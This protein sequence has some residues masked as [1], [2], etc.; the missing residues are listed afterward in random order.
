M[1]W[2]PSK[3]YFGA[4]YNPEQWDPSTWHDDVLAMRDMGVNMVTVGVFSWAV[5]EPKPEKYEFGWLDDVMDLLHNAGV[6]VDLATATASPPPWLPLLDPSVCAVR[7]DGAHYSHGGRQHYSASSRTYREKAAQLV[8]QMAAR[9]SSHPAL[10]MWHVNNE[11]ACHVPQCY[12]LEAEKAFRKWLID[13][14]A[15]IDELNDAWQTRFWSQHY[16]DFEQVAPPRL[17]SATPN[18]GQVLDFQRFSSHQWLE[19]FRLEKSMI[20]RHDHIHPITTNFMTMRHFSSLNYWDWVDEVD[21]VSTDHYADASDSDRHIELAFH[22]DLT[23]GLAG[24]KPWLLMEHSPS[25]VNWQPRNAAKSDGEILRHSLSHIARGSNGAM[26]FQFKQSRGGSERFH[27]AMVPHV[28]RESR[29]TRA[30][31]RLGASIKDLNHLNNETVE[32]AKVAIIWDYESLWA[33]TLENL[34]SVDLNYFESVFRMYRALFALGVRV[35]ILPA[36]A[37]AEDLAHYTLVVAPTL[38]LIDDT[39]ETTVS[40]YVNDGG[41]LITGYFS[42]VADRAGRV[43]LGGYGGELLRRVCGV[44]VEEFAPLQKDETVELTNGYQAQVWSEV[45]TALTA[46]PIARYPSD[47]PVSGGSIALSRN[48]YGKGTAWYVGTELADHSM[49][50]FLSGVMEQLGISGLGSKH[51][52]VVVRGTTQIVINHSDEPVLVGEAEVGA[53]GWTT[54]PQS[55]ARSQDEPAS[56]VT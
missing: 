24:G 28:G 56:L 15:T 2:K 47:Y 40:E 27:A 29:I 8:D 42:A 5:I 34:P 36:S 3:L 26:F 21:F 53:G 52:E 55:E 23:R 17:V 9:Y 12:G 49:E 6:M 35:D 1:T 33:L 50:A 39:F 48:L 43:R 46:T 19:L 51:V 45:A 25:A 38:H 20:R 37:Q 4:D 11:Y 14:Y 18:P 54:V 44:A 22:A 41:N 30:M 7:P 10:E 13:R 31:T 32:Q 16:S